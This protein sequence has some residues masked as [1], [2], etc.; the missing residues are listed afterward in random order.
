[1]IGRRQLSFIR[2]QLAK[3]PRIP[4]EAVNGVWEW[5]LVPGQVGVVKIP[6]DTGL[7]DQD[8]NQRADLETVRLEHHI[9]LRDKIPLCEE[10]RFGW[11]VKSGCV[12]WQLL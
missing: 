10:I 9:V 11:G 3:D 12:V 6:F 8:G 2:D 4:R 7:V 1:M 5:L